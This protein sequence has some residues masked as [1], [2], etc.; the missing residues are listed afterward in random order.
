MLTSDLVTTELMLSGEADRVRDSAG[1]AVGENRAP[2]LRSTSLE[3]EVSDVRR[4]VVQLHVQL[5]ARAFPRPVGL[6]NVG[7]S[8]CCRVVTKTAGGCR[9]SFFDLIWCTAAASERLRCRETRRQNRN[10]LISIQRE[11][12][13]DGAACICHVDRWKVVHRLEEAA[14]V[15]GHC[16]REAARGLIARSIGGRDVDRGRANEEGRAGGLAGRDV[17]A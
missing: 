11:L 3:L 16:H 15:V 17:D 12:D 4:A 9:G 14:E 6:P 10:S 13:R 1:R 8:V 2:G 5:A 7:I